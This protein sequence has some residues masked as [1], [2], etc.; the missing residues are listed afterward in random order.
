MKVFLWWKLLVMKFILWWKLSSDENLLVMKVILWW[1]LKLS[2]KWKGVICNLCN[3]TKD[4][5]SLEESYR[6]CQT[7]CSVLEFE[8][9]KWDIS[10]LFNF[11]SWYD[12]S[13]WITCT[14][15]GSEFDMEGEMWMR[16]WSQR[17][18]RSPRSS[19][20]WPT[21]GWRWPPSGPAT[22]WALGQAT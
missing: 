6:H 16:A 5:K 18:W 7:K 9:N 13:R 22:W 17:C 3:P 4:T 12:W 2:K 19:R 15:C 8:K 11:P 14:K 21:W 1:K 20:E 10:K